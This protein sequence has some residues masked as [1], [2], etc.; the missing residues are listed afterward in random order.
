MA[1]S[2]AAPAPVRAPDAPRTRPAVVAAPARPTSR[3]L[4][5]VAIVVS[6]TA[7]GTAGLFGRMATPPGVVAGE[8]LTLG[9]MLA[10]AVGML[11]LLAAARRLGHLRRTR[12]TR[13][14]VLGGVFLGLSLATYLSSAVL[15]DLKLAVVLHYLGPV[16]ATVLAATVLKERVSRA[17]VVS[18]GASFLGMLLAAGLLDGAP[19]A[20]S[21]DQTLGVVL[22][23]VSGVLYGGALLSYR[24]RSDMP[25]DVRS[26]WNFLFGA[27]ATG[28]MVAVT[29][30]DLSGMTGDHWAWA[31]AFFL[32]CGL[33][34]LGLLVVAGKHLRS[35]ELSA[36]SYW[37][38]VVALLLGAAVFGESITPLA[39]VGAALIVIG[40]V[41]PSAQA[42]RGD[43]PRD[44]ERA[45]GR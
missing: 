36:L 19:A 25:T 35:V 34:A 12:V 32:V 26:F 8:A 37:E 43:G 18:L 41:V 2:T 33:L 6:A 15:I 1:V 5:I 45:P 17:D 16:L 27:L 13:S 10:G 28:A 44:V 31:V 24:Y 9:R 20:T 22:G 4:G 3:R 39:T 38:I 7:M 29:Q 42:A 14:V 40:A 21:S 30:P 23:V 11:A